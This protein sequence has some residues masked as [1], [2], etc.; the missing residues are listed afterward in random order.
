LDE[1]FTDFVPNGNVG[2]SVED[3]GDFLGMDA[4][5]PLL[6]SANTTDGKAARLSEGRFWLVLVGPALSRWRWVV[7]VFI[8]WM[9]G[10]LYYIVRIPNVY[11]SEAL[12]VPVSSG[13]SGSAGAYGGLASL[14]G[15]SLGGGAPDKTALSLE[16]LA[17]RAFIREFVRKQDLAAA[18]IAGR[19]WNFEERKWIYDENLYDAKSGRWLVSTS[20]DGQVGPSD[21]QIYSKFSQEVL[22][23]NHDKK[24]GLVR[25]GVRLNSP[26]E[27]QRWA[28]LVVK[29]LN[30]YI[31]NRDVQEAQKSIAY[32][33]QQV[34][35]TNAG[36]MKNIFYQ[37]IEEQTKTVMLAEVREGYVFSVVDP[38]VVPQEKIFPNRTSS[39]I[40]AAVF[41]VCVS[42]FCV[43]LHHGVLVTLRKASDASR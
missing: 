42:V 15:L 12:L 20:K 19:G 32:L 6:G 26:S 34:S 29:D 7:C 31:R 43:L 10:A 40:F 22:S 17:S 8:F 37:L 33:Q 2:G 3:L 24:S 14:V 35:R 16:I 25:V 11:Q 5:L 21:W 39:V 9:A 27:A 4:L 23:V 1:C 28:D 36:E 13:R 30:D 41:G 18:L 38:P